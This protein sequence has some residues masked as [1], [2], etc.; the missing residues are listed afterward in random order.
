MSTFIDNVK[1]IEKGEIT[2]IGF[3]RAGAE[4]LKKRI[5]LVA[6]VSPEN[7]GNTAGADA[8]L[9]EVT[10][11]VT[12]ETLKNVPKTM[13]WGARLRAVNGNDIPKM[14]NAGCDFFV[15]TPDTPV[16]LVEDAKAG[17][18]LAVD[19]TVADSLYRTLIDLPVDALMIELP[20]ANETITW[21]DLMLVQ[22][23]GVIPGKPLFVHSAVKLSAAE[24]EALWCAGVNAVVA[25]NNLEDIRKEIEKA[26][27]R[28]KSKTDKKEPV[29]R[30]SVNA[31][32]DDADDDD[33]DE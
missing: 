21:Q 33:F 31:G 9:V 24:L 6:A 4:T 2:P 15:F 1:K 10:G 25:E 20:A 26:D 11:K 22:K 23:F 8:V 29:L 14:V 30:Q 16:T 13:P 19:I 27:F 5:Q 12:A 32:F 7:S 28:K 17:K 18:V 3:R